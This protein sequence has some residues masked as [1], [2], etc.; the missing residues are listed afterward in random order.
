MVVFTGLAALLGERSGLFVSV[1]GVVMA[2][3]PSVL[4]IRM[5]TALLLIL[6][7]S[8]Q[9]DFVLRRVRARRKFLTRNSRCALAVFAAALLGSVLLLLAFVL[10]LRS[11]C[12]LLE[13][14]HESSDCG[15][16]R[17]SHVGGFGLLKAL[18]P[19][20]IEGIQIGA[21]KSFISKRS[22]WSGQILDHVV[23]SFK[24]DLPFEA[25]HRARF[26]A[27]TKS[28]QLA[29]SGT[30][31]MLTHSLCNVGLNDFIQGVDSRCLLVVENGRKD[32]VGWRLQHVA[33]LRCL[34]NVG[35]GGWQCLHCVFIEEC[36][37]D[38]LA[39]IDA[40]V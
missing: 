9:L 34:V 31:S 39:E 20:P 40:I 1:L 7:W 25:L 28:L 6:R 5:Q 15:N 27:G 18:D 38:E 13:L 12:T 11:S 37:L 10:T 32:R 23:G 17:V 35:N 4:V 2:F 36:M 21:T 30:L 16:R 29:I 3:A 14:R 19:L 8:K 33:E 24:G 26:L 22:F